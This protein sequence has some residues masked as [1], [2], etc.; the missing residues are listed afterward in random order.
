MLVDMLPFSLS[1]PSD[2]RH[3]SQTWAVDAVEQTLESHKALLVAAMASE[4]EKLAALQASESK[5]G[6]NCKEAE[7]ALLAQTEVVAAA[8][9]GSAAA[10]E[11]AAGA[12]SA[13]TTAQDEHKAAESKLATTKDEL[14]MFETTVAEHFKTPMEAGAGPHYKELQ[15]L[16]KHIEMD[17]S[18]SKALSSSC[19]KSKEDRGS[20]DEVVLKEFEKAL[21]SKIT[22]LTDAV[23]ADTPGLAQLEAVAQAAEK[24]RDAK[25]DAQ[26]QA[27]E[28][29]EGAEK[30]QTDKEAA[31]AAAN[32]ASEDFMPQLEEMAGLVDKA[33]AALTSFESG[34][35]SGFSKYKA[36][37]A[38]TGEAAPMGA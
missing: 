10:S 25:V 11:A 31:L 33:R 27:A 4:E 15:P 1:I 32:K 34:A 2:Q 38:V 8:K 23:A 30:E 7:T 16:L 35:L 37:V 12:A 20:F 19:G 14:Q 28:A 6:D 3:E 18:L 24:E 36:Q 13:L 21:T 17:V 26:K 22:S 9:A 29:L 5:L